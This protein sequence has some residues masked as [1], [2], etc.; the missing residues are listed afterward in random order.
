VKALLLAVSLS[1]CATS[2]TATVNVATNSLDA[3]GK[4]FLATA[5]ALDAAYDAKMVSEMQYDAW[6]DFAARFKAAFAIADKAMVAAQQSN[7]QTVIGVVKSEMATLE[8]ELA[9]FQALAGQVVHPTTG[10]GT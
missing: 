5:A 3:T 6:R 2:A 1:A 9:T 4:L 7:D 10:G 8:K